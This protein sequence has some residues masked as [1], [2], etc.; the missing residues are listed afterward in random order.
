MLTAGGQLSPPLLIEGRGRLIERTIV[1]E[2]QNPNRV[3]TAYDHTRQAAAGS[4]SASIWAGTARLEPSQPTL[5]CLRIDTYC[6]AIP[7]ESAR[8]F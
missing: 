7:K 3:L 2:F 5:R 1:R 8:P 6:P 4:M